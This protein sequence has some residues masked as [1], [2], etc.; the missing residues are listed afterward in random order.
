M[1]KVGAFLA[2]H[3][4]TVPA[5]TAA[6]T[7]PTPASYCGLTYHGIHAFGFVAD[8]GS[9]RH[10]RYHLMPDGGDQSL[11][12]EEA[13][14]KSPDYLREDLQAALRRAERDSAA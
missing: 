7:H 13:S 2:E 12:D 11:T 14:A 1:E 5:V 9:V 6:I 10:G 3:P 8:D 4:E